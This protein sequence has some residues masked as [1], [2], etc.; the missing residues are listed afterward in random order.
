MSGAWYVKV[1]GRQYP[2]E[3]TAFVQIHIIYMLTIYSDGVISKIDG[4]Q[5]IQ[6]QC[7]KATYRLSRDT[8]TAEYLYSSGMLPIEKLT[9]VESVPCSQNG[10]VPHQTQFYFSLIREVHGI[11]TRQMDNM[12]IFSQH[13]VLLQSLNEYNVIVN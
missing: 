3:V 10:R 6:N 7:V 1:Q 4:L 2:K 9:I 5:R 12:H 11:Y 13:S 8:P